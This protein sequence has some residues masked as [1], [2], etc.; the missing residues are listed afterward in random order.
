MVPFTL[1]PSL[2]PFL[3]EIISSKDVTISI[4]PQDKLPTVSAD[5]CQNVH[6]YFYDPRAL[7]SIYTVSCSNVVVHLQPPYKEEMVL[8]LPADS[9]EQFV[10]TLQRGKMVTEMVIRGRKRGRGKGRGKIGNGEV[11]GV[12]FSGLFVY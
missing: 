11:V 1:P 4:N 7:G 5:G 3:Q 10:S 2:P 8:D 12:F 9:T 6:L